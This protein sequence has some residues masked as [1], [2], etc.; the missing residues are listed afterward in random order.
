M[1]S[2]HTAAT[3]ASAEI[4]ETLIVED[5]Q[6]MRK[7]REERGLEGREGGGGKKK[8]ERRRRRRREVKG[9]KQRSTRRYQVRL[10]L[11]RIIS[12]QW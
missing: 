11:H 4:V 5:V 7:G 10:T 6:K 12:K 9:L 3:M 8:K 1:C 2:S